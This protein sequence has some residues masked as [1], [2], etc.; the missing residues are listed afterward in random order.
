M[1][2]T[3]RNRLVMA[4]VAGL[5][6]LL[7][8]TLGVNCKTPSPVV[9]ENPLPPLDEMGLGYT[10]DDLYDFGVDRPAKEI[11]CTITEDPS[12]NLFRIQKWTGGN[13]LISIPKRHT[14]SLFCDNQFLRQY[15]FTYQED[16][17]NVNLNDVT[18]LPDRI[19]FNSQGAIYEV[20]Y[21]GEVLY[22]L[23]V[24]RLT[25]QV[26]LLDNG[27]YLIVRSGYDQVAE[28][29]REGVLV[30]QW[31]A[32]ENFTDYDDSNYTGFSNISFVDQIVNF[33]SDYEQQV[34]G[35]NDRWEWTHVNSVQKIGDEFLINLRNLDLIIRVNRDGDIVWSFGAL[36]TRHGH[37]PV[38]LDNGNL[39]FYDN[40]NGRV[41]EFDVRTQKVVW[42][43][44]G[45]NSP[46]MGWI[47][48][49][50]NG[51]YL[52]PDSCEGRVI[53]ANSD[54]EIVKL[55]DID[56]AGMN[57]FEKQI[58]QCKAYPSSSVAWLNR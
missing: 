56:T 13:L 24:S 18:L 45:L 3:R 43:F 44:G 32:V 5:V 33:Y 53:E 51:N 25:H 57:I 35:S 36:L 23:N 4:S 2:G 11:V 52:F 17:K 46:V 30:W 41:V 10:V 12:E 39:I 27:N 34:V 54:G 26:E 8:L 50:S 19:L 37:H 20:N 15:T 21:S 14:L 29:T 6:F 58:Y 40:G 28:I 7:V 47:Q 38:L 16:S 22:S 1:K 55:I 49:L 31:N 42:Q 9:E 48:K